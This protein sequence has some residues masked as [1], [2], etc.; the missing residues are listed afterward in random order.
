MPLFACNE[1]DN[2]DDDE[3]KSAEEAR[4]IEREKKS[5]QTISLYVCAR[6]LMIINLQF[7]YNVANRNEPIVCVIIET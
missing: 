6:A 3:K 5:F 2:D 4:E 7:G 1:V